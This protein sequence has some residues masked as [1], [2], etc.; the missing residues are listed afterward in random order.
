MPA[1]QDLRSAWSPPGGRWWTS[2]L[3]RGRIMDGV[4]FQLPRCFWLKRLSGQRRPVSWTF[5]G[6]PLCEVRPGNPVPVQILPFLSPRDH[7]GGQTRT[8]AV[9]SGGCSLSPVCQ[10]PARAEGF[11]RT[12]PQQ[13]S[14]EGAFTLPRME[15]QELG[16]CPGA[17]PHGR[18]PKAGLGPL[19]LGLAARLV[20]C[21]P[22]R[23]PGPPVSTLASGPS[24]DPPALSVPVADTC[25]HPRG[26]PQGQC[27]PVVKDSRV[28]IGEPGSSPAG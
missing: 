21:A 3:R 25:G 10:G 11:T 6:C 17:Q 8:V 1:R 28:H 2:G 19:W 13:V 23:V 22:L 9:A 5:G 14:E 7:Q 18:E 20:P 16:P 24:L 27:F 15:T 26:S 4:S 12:C